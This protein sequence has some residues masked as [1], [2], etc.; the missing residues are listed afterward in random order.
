MSDAAVQD[1]VR[2]VVAELLKVPEE[3]VTPSAHFVRDLGME[4][5]QS[6]EIVAA[7]EEEFDIEIDEDEVANVL[8]FE[9]SLTY[10]EGKLN[11]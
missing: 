11:G 7:I 2:K 3:K 8:T 10:V 5:V 1:R 4:S 9:K 6:I